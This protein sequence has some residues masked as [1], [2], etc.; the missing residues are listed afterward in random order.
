[1]LVVIDRFSRK[2]RKFILLLNH[3]FFF[4]LVICD[5]IIDQKN[6][7]HLYTWIGAIPEFTS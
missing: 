5:G 1:M 2:K 4:F 3:F 7:G 6:R